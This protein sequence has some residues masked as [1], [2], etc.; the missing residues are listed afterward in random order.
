MI[1]VINTIVGENRGKAR[2]WLEGN[3]IRP[4][5]EP[6]SFFSKIVDLKN[7]RIVLCQDDS[8]SHKVSIRNRRDK[9]LPLIEIKGDDVLDV[10]SLKM[11]LR[12]IVRKGQITIE[13]H[14][15]EKK[16]LEKAQQFIN[17]VL[18]NEPIIMGSVYTGLGVLDKSIH[19]GLKDKG[20]ESYTKF[21]LER[22]SNYIEACLSNQK[23][24]FRED[25]IIVHSSI[26]DVEFS[27]TSST[28]IDLLVGSLPCTGASKAGRSKKKLKSAEFDSDCGSSFFY[29]LNFIKHFK[30]LVVLMENVTE[31][32]ETASMQVIKSVL[33]TLGYSINT[34]TLNG[35]LFGSIE[36]RDR[37]AFIAINNKL[38]E[39][40]NFDTSNIKPFKTIQNNINDILEPIELDSPKW[41][42]YS[43]LADKE[44]RD[45]KAKKG[46]KRN[47]VTG[48]ER[49]IGTIR[50]LYHKGGSCDQF[51]R[52]P[53]NTSLTRLFTS[54]EHARMKG[55]PE[56]LIDGLSE[57]VAHE[58]LG[59][60]ICF[61]AFQSVGRALGNW[62]LNFK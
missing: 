48:T 55:I 25:S 7:K 46:F 21:V 49:T 50:R 24:L 3:K 35:N 38:N 12:V 41:K 31:Y 22:E 2:I 59:Q 11:K 33:N 30:P 57:T 34:L 20:L 42:T 60:S 40:N 44:V 32:L 61:P 6:G 53:Y 23:D 62:I 18:N 17:K 1:T 14:E 4:A 56:N 43:Y 58:L 54:K 47:I 29:W 8:G 37:L 39:I 45:I 26:E 27:C 9:A 5:F 13:I 28:D 51:I 15:R 10:F 16:L 36:N 19:Q 52:H